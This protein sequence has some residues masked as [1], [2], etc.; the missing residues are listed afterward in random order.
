MWTY[1]PLA[2]PLEPPVLSVYWWSSRLVVCP[3]IAALNAKKTPPEFS[4]VNQRILHLTIASVWQNGPSWTIAPLRRQRP[5]VWGGLL[6]RD[7]LLQS[8]PAETQLF[9]GSRAASSAVHCHGD[10]R[11]WC[12]I[13]GIEG[14]TFYSDTGNMSIF[15][16]SQKKCGFF[17]SS[18]LNK[19]DVYCPP[20][21]ELQ[22]RWCYL[23]EKMVSNYKI[24]PEVF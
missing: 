11:G 6:S 8:R 19:W 13:T 1:T 9:S 24:I 12:V 3:L 2:G 17:F 10:L 20:E 15:H 14:R 23:S 7:R 18:F 4:E 22:P 16:L 21:L 5:V